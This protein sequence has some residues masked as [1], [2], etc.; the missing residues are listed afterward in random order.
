MMLPRP[1]AGTL[2]LRIAVFTAVAGLLTVFVTLGFFRFTV[3]KVIADQVRATIGA[4]LD[5]L[6]EAY[7]RGGRTE[8]ASV[9]RRRLKTEPSAVYALTDPGGRVIE[10]NLLDWPPTLVRAR[11]VQSLDLYLKDAEAPRAVA[12]IGLVMPDGARLLVGSDQHNLRRVGSALGESLLLALG[13]G[14][15]LML[16]V[17]WLVSRFLARQ[18]DAISSTARAIMAGHLTERVRRVGADDAFDRLAVTLNAMLDRIEALIGELRM[19]TDSLAHDLKSPITRLK[20]RLENALALDDPQRAR[21][22][23]LGAAQETDALLR[24]LDGLLAISRA[25]AGLGAEQMHSLDSAQMVDDLAELY[26]PS[27]EERGVTLETAI[28]GPALVRAHPELLAQALANLIDNA[29]NHGGKGRIT[30]AVANDGDMV[31]LTV[32]DTG[33]GIP[34][35]RRNEAL[36][37]FG[38][39]DPARSAPGSGLGLALVNAIARMHGGVLELAD[40]EPGLAAT[41]V[42]PAQSA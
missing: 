36:A 41:I 21:P 8:A 27:A 11:Q 28:A 14:I 30:L 40:A 38:R 23:L 19:V 6:A 2:T 18:V 35:E 42:L 39:L 15:L 20:G 16:S 29:I 34:H 4:E 1:L 26:Q 37:R 7:G 33:P 9:I 32:A 3:E 10:G 24:Q 25:E 5:G 13:V 12:V 31:R 22:A 17:G